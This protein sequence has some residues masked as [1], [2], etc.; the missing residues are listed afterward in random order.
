MEKKFNKK[1][2]TA[3]EFLT[4]YGWAFVIIL[5]M[6]GTLAYFG[7]LSPSQI[8]PERCSISPEIGCVQ[9]LIGQTDAGTGVLRLRLKNNVPE[10]IVVA[11]L[12]TTSESAT[13]FTCALKPTGG[14]WT[15]QEVKDFEFTGCNNKDAGLVLGNKGKVN[16][17]VSFYLA[18]SSSEFSKSVEGEIF[19]TVT[20]VGGLLTQ[21]N[22]SDDTDNDANGCIDYVG[23]DTGC[24][25]ASDTSESG[26]TCPNAGGQ[27]L[28]LYCFVSTS[29]PDT[30]VFKVS[31][32]KDAHAEIPSL[33]NYDYKACCRTSSD[34]L[35]N[36]CTSPDVVPLHLSASTDAHVE[37]N[38]FA[39]Y[40][41]NVCLS[42]NTKT[43]SCSY[44]ANCLADE[45]C[46]AT[47]SAD[48]DAHIG[49]CVTQPFATK[50]CCRIL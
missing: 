29:C 49:D 41:T 37:K 16:V 25:S 22:C 46:L 14:I 9:S 17:K 38:T 45:T 33:S 8:L 19:A 48:T 35:S 12:D 23:G 30:T 39:N 7:I 26:G 21:V 4:T 3:L 50:I 11:S 36:S 43:I 44:A 47:I 20:R 42:A 27:G 31:A 32:L 34:T 18:S 2:Q 40:A 13:P 28:N 6:I 15:S 24:S 1:S 10:P 5:L